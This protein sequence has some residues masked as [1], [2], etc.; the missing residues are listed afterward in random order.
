MNAAI[1]PHDDPAADAESTL[2]DTTSGDAPTETGH[3][4]EELDDVTDDG[5]SGDGTLGDREFT[6]AVDDLDDNHASGGWSARS[7]DESPLT[8]DSDGEQDGDEHLADEL[9]A[10]AMGRPL[11][12]SMNDDDQGMQNAGANLGS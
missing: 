5:S 3:G 10:D 6:D 11:D 4:P 2:G 8:I 1:T 9:A 12:G 7:D